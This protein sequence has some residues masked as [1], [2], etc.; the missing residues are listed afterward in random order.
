MNENMQIAVILPAAGQSRRFIA[1]SAGNGPRASKL[2]SDLGGRTVLVRTIELFAGV[3]GVCQIIVAVDPEQIDDFKFR[4]EDK[5]SFI[6]AQIVAG[7]KIE[8]W[9]TVLCALRA[10]KQEATHIAVHDAARPVTDAAMIH[11]VFEAA[12]KFNAVIPGVPASATMKRAILDEQASKVEVDPLDAILG[13]AGKEEIRAY[14]VTETVSRENLWMIQTPQVFER[15][16]M[17]RAYDQLAAGGMGGAGITDDAGLIERLGEPVHII[18]GDAMNVKITTREDLKFAS[19]VLY[20]RSGQQ[21]KEAIG[22]KRKFATWKEM[23][24]D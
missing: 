6:G 1:S 17:Q 22:P 16:L 21:S 19:A 23:D 7:G 24:E 20:L 9:E 10:V 14:R 3:K 15:K 5:L 8:R 18:E 13:S 4:W 11:R 2:E 12:K